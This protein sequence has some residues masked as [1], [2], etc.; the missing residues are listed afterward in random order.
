MQIKL[1]FKE[2]KI[3][4]CYK[5]SSWNFVIRH[6]STKIK[7]LVNTVKSKVELH[8]PVKIYEIRKNF[9]NK[10]TFF[11]KMYIFV[12]NFKNSIKNQKFNFLTVLCDIGKKRKNAKLSLQWS[13]QILVDTVSDRMHIFRFNFKKFD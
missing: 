13:L 2:F 9:R 3:F 10:I 11:Y 4:L 12:F 6:K 1:K 7:Y 8:F 5:L